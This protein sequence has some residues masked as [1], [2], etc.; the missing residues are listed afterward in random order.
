MTI[1]DANTVR[2]IAR[3]A[4]QIGA[5]LPEKIT[6]ALLHLEDL[7]RNRPAAPQ[8]G[9]MARDLAQHL[10]EPAAMDKA[11]KAAAA[12]LASADAAAKIHMFLAE[13]CGAR[14]R[15]MMRDETEQIAGAFGDALA[16]DLAT[17]TATAGRLPAWFKPDQSAGLDPGTFEAWCLARDAYSRVQSASA[18]LG[19]LYGS[20]IDREHAIHFPTTAGVTLRFAKPP[21]LATLP[22]AYAF[23]HALAGRTERGQAGAGQGSTFIEGLFIPTALAQVGATFEWATPTE[24]HERAEQIVAGMTAKPAATGTAPRSSRDVLILP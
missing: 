11:L 10:G 22:A 14:V 8:P 24:V 9:H 4:N 16:D 15:A 19:P 12:A 6:R 13:T 2:T 20:A 23:R 21:R 5:P 18:A 1:Q 17:L 7:T 3:A